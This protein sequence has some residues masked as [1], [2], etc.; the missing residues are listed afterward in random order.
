MGRWSYSDRLTTDE[1]KSISIKFL[2]R[3]NY[4]DDLDYISSG[5]MT[6][7]RGDVKTSNIGFTVSTVQSDECVRFQYTQTDRNTGEKTELDYIVQLTWTP[8]YFGGRRWWFLCPLTANGQYCGRRVG[9]LY[10]GGGKYFGC[11]HC[12]NLTY[13]SCQDSHKFDR[14][15]M[16]MGI[17][18]KAVSDL[19]RRSRLERKR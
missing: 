17:P 6:W 19:F 18:P 8:C 3:H 10:L 2:K 4:F 7:S 1:C 12:Y 14:L 5:G 13:E 15:F 16:G 9:V 11:R